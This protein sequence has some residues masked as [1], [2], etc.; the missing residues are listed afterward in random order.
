MTAGGRVLRYSTEA[1]YPFYI[2]H[3]TVLIGVAYVV[4]QWAWAPWAKF[5]LIIVA[6]LGLTL[7]IYE[8]AVRRW[9]PVRFLFG[10]KPRRRATTPAQPAVPPAAS[11]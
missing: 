9:G 10:M 8:V 11:A 2:L 4:C 7:G 3:Q 6:S 5:T 1:A